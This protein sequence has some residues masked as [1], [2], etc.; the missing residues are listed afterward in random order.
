[1]GEGRCGWVCKASG[2]ADDA[3]VS[4]HDFDKSARAVIGDEVFA[5]S[6]LERG[7]SGEEGKHVADAKLPRVLWP[8]RATRSHSD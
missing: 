3:G 5:E 1:V 8:A 6:D 7:G 4:G 2:A